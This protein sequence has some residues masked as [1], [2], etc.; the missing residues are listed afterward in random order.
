MKIKFDYSHVVKE[1]P[2]LKD[3][4][5]DG[6]TDFNRIAEVIG[7]REAAVVWGIHNA[8]VGPKVTRAQADR[9]ARLIGKAKS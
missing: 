3:F 8:L 4:A 9:L 2:E 7:S 1:F 6:K 5:S